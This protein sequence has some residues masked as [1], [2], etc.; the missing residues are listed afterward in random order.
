MWYLYAPDTYIR[1]TY[2]TL[3]DKCK[4]NVSRVSVYHGKPW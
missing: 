2:V 1:M 4:W 3:T